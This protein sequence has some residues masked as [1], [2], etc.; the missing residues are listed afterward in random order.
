MAEQDAES[1][2]GKDGGDVEDGA[3]PAKHARRLADAARTPAEALPASG[4]A[5][6]NAGP[7]RYAERYRLRPGHHR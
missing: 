5:G 3:E 2:P 7:R 4:D 1:G 6:E